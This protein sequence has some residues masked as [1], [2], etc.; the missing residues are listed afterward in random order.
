MAGRKPNSLPA[1]WPKSTANDLAARPQRIVILGQEQE[2]LFGGNS[3]KTSKYEVYNFLPKFLFEEFNPNTKIANCYFLVIAALQCVRVISNT[4]GYPT[5]LIPLTGVLV[6]AGILKVLEDI[7][8]HKADKAANSSTTE[9]FDPTSKTFITKLWSEVVVGD[10]V[11]VKSREPVPADLVIIQVWEPNPDVAKGACYVETKSLDGET[12]LKHRSVPAPLVGKIKTTDDIAKLRGRITME[13]PNNLID[14]FTGILESPDF[15]KMPLLPGNVILRGC[16]L[17]STDFMVG[18]AVNTGH[19]VKVM[20]S[21]LEAKVKSSALEVTA[22]QQIVRVF[23]MLF[24][25]AFLGAIGSV[26]T[27]SVRDINSWWYLKYD[28]SL[29]ATFIIQFFYYLLLHATF[30]PVSLYVSMAFVRFFQ[31][32]FVQFDLDMY[33]EPLDAPAIVRTMTLCEELGQI[34][35]I[36]SDKTGTLTCNVMN[37]RKASIYGTSYGKGITE[38]GRAAWKLLN[39]PI[40]ADVLAAEESAKENSVPHVSFYC[41]DFDRDMA[42]ENSIERRKIRD[43]YRFIA[44]CHEVIAE[45]LEDGSSRLSAPNPDDEAL[46]CAAAH[47][48]F[49]FKD[50][51]DRFVALEDKDTGKELL[52]EVF[53]VIPFTSARKRMSVIFRDVDNKIKIVTKGADSMMFTRVDPADEEINN[54]TA[55]HIDQY[56]I[57]GLRCLVLAA[58]E[59]SEEKFN[60]W[61]AKYEAASSDLNELEKKKRGETNDIET[62]E[63]FI[64]SG[65]HVVGATAIEDRLQDGVP[66]T[67]ENLTKAGIKVWVLTGDKEETAINIAVA[68][69]LVLPKDYMDQCVINSSTAPSLLHA[70]L[71]LIKEILRYKHETIGLSDNESIDG[72]VEVIHV[73]KTSASLPPQN[74]DDSGKLGEAKAEE[75]TGIVYAFELADIRP[76][77]PT[78]RPR[79][80]VIDGPTLI[81]IMQDKESRH[82]LLLFSQCC[83][84]V[85]CCRVS[86][87]Q[88][89][90]IV[91]LVKNNVEGVRTLS[92]GDG[93]NDVAMITTAHVGVGIRGEEGVQAV[94]AADFSIGQ[95]RFLSN[96]LL[97]HGRANYQRMSSLICYMF[98]KNIFMSA[99]MFW[100]NFFNAFSGLKFYGEAA[101]QLFNLFYTS[102]PIIM[103]AAYDSDLDRKTILQ[104]PQLY[105]ACI[106]GKYF[107]DSIFW[108]W[109]TNAVLESVFCAI[110]PLYALSNFDYRTGVMAVFNEPGAFCFTAVVIICNYKLL[111]V[112]SNWYKMSVV[113][114][115]LSIGSWILIAY[116]AN[117]LPLVDFHFF[118]V[119][120]RLLQ[121]GDFW[122]L[123]LLVCTAVGLKDVALMWCRRQIF[124]RPEDILQ[125][126]AA[127]QSL[128]ARDVSDNNQILN[129]K[130]SNYI[131]NSNSSDRYASVEMTSQQTK[132]SAVD[133]SGFVVV[134]SDD[135][136]QEGKTGKD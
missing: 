37:F 39:K 26:I 135:L 48:A 36:F 88:K 134:P 12:N 52:I 55:Q 136:Q 17:R 77:P 24:L 29:G 60:A 18:L 93:A 74:L 112:Q 59:I 13:H 87:D 22:T 4:G 30:V 35:H 114:I 5:V 95:F 11:R 41:P 38:I 7:Q 126:L 111:R 116:I 2:Y 15:G 69:N 1:G 110:L 94:N 80:L 33:Y 46:V 66:E 109:V 120:G 40:P 81:P 45:R 85:V 91:D 70:K 27:N 50:R 84:A 42:K 57:E 25:L 49:A 98:Y 130:T 56:S 63:D 89:R 113:A 72:I 71:L 133:K 53:T 127:A 125:E 100:Y 23:G 82:L 107:N 128:Q 131:L 54:L 34:S 31:S 62:L 103:Y 68:C 8:R 97:R 86:P 83:Q 28:Q 14:S 51:R 118:H 61:R 21:K 106:Q 102:I 117:V 129:K 58:A 67:I 96:L 123:L 101:I 6:I 78:S 73:D 99:C 90:E 3:I 104:F 79:A 32:R 124:Y 44:V 115:L 10:Y 20:Q 92:V 119:W 16:V 65:L 64:E 47:F 121:S 122:L 76:L 9:V 19:D 105:R 132:T 108:M 43:F 75:E